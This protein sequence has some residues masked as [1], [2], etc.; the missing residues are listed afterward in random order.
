M[1]ASTADLVTELSLLAC[2]ALCTYFA[3]RSYRNSKSGYIDNGSQLATNVGVFFTFAG[4]AIGLYFFDT[5]ADKLQ[6]SVPT[7]LAGMKTAFGT[8]IIG[9]IFAFIIR[10]I[11]SGKE[12]KA[13]EV[14][15]E[16]MD[17]NFNAS[18]NLAAVDWQNIV[19]KPIA[20]LLE[21]IQMLRAAVEAQTSTSLANELGSLSQTIKFFADQEKKSFEATQDLIG[22]M[23]AQAK[24][25]D[26]LGKEIK[27]ASV[28]TTEKQSAYLEHMD[29][30]IAQ[31]Q[32]DTRESYSNSS[33]LLENANTFQKLSL[34]NQKE[35]LS[36]LV[37]N[38]QQIVEMKQAFNQFLDD[39]AKKNNEEFIKALN[40]SMQR[41]NEQLVDQFGENFKKLNEAVYVLKDWQENYLETIEK[42]TGEL[43]SLRGA[44]DSYLSEYLPQAKSAIENVNSVLLPQMNGTISGIETQVRALDESAQQNM[45]TMRTML[46][47][48]HRLNDLVIHT[49]ECTS[50]METLIKE[51]SDDSRD[52][53]ESTHT[54]VESQNAWISASME[55][56]GKNL[57]ASVQKASN[58]MLDAL[59]ATE[60]QHMAVFGDAAQ[61]VVDGFKRVSESAVVTQV[62]VDDSVRKLDNTVQKAMED[63]SRV[64]EGFN[65]DMDNAVNA[66][67]Q[68]LNASLETITRDT[69]EQGK[70]SVEQLAGVL[71]AVSDRMV[72]NY[73]A[74][75]DKLQEVDALLMDRRRNA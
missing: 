22:H 49:K 34:E 44:F 59:K 18:K 17:A 74:L 8:S 69:G 61:Q 66:S 29:K 42:T 57:S 25:F 70:K 21:E 16:Q 11:Q 38:T 23:D 63:I 43:E 1:N 71:G 56:M 30:N 19:A 35:Q 62:D 15:S 53:I 47:A 52:M 10:F 65:A 51:V 45:Q 60:D 27:S 41:L 3:V 67:M 39:M 75:V 73:N 24:A 20:P 50:T 4:I 54:A 28:E 36:V 31:M 9:M 12:K 14:F 33:Q 13:D 55:S 32:E 46:D 7:F 5:D 6:E 58:D 48:A 26:T 64:I 40:E 2:C 68:R 72:S 37:G